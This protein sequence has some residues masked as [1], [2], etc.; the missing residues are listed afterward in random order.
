MTY[1]EFLDT[2]GFQESSNIYNKENSLGYIG[3]YQFG[4]SALIYIG[5]YVA[6]GTS[7]N[8]WIGNWTLA[9]GVSSKTAFLNNNNAQ[10]AAILAYMAKQWSYVNSV[11]QYEGQILNGVKITISGMLAGAHLV[12][13]VGEKQYLNSGGDVVPVDGNKTPITKYMQQF[14]G[15][16]TPFS[17][18][19]SIDETIKGGKGNDTLDGGNGFDTYIASNGDTLNDTDGKGKVLF[20]NIELR[21]GTKNSGETEWKDADGHTYS[22]LGSRLLITNSD[23]TSTLTIEN[24]SNDDL[25]IHLNDIDQ[26]TADLFNAAT[27]VTAPIRYDPLIFDLNGNGIESTG[28]SLTNPIYFDNDADGIKTATGWVSVNDAFL[29]LDKNSNGAIDDGRELF[30]D[31]MIKGNGE[32]ATDGFDALRDLDSNADGKIDSSDA[33]FA[34]LRLWQDLN[35]D[36]ISQSD[37]LFTL[38]SQNIAAINVGSTANNQILSNGNQLADVGSFIRTDGSSGTLG[39]VTGNIGDINLAQNTFLS[40]FVDHLDTSA[41][42]GLPDM[43]GAGQVRTLREAA[44]LS[45]TLAQLL[46][47]YRAA[48]DYS[49]RLALLDP[50]LTAWSDTSTLATTFNG[51]YSGHRLTVNIAGSVPGS[52]QYNAVANELTILEHFNGRTF[53]TVP[54]GTEAVTITLWTTTQ[55]LLQNSYDTLKQSV[56][57]SLAFQTNLKPYLDAISLGVS[58]T[59]ISLDFTGMNALLASN[60]QANPANA[61]FDLIELNRYAG[62]KLYSTGWDGI[63]QLQSWVE[64]ASGDTQL[65]TILTTMGVTL[66]PGNFSGGGADDM[67]F[68]QGGNDTLYGQAGNDILSGGTG[69]DSLNGGSGN[70]TLSGGTGNDTLVGEFGNDTLDGGASNDTLI[71]GTGNNT[72]LFGIG[73]GQD[74]INPIS[75]TTAGKLSTLQFKAGVAAADVVITQVYDNIFNGNR[76]LQIAIVG[77]TD[78]IIINGFFYNDDPTSAYNSVQQI[79]FADGAVWNIAT[80]QAMLFAGSSGNDAI[81]GT[82]ANDSLTGGLGNDSLNGAA[83]NDTING[84][85]GNDD[86]DGSA[87]IDTLL[88]GA[89]D[90][91]YRIGNSGDVIVEN[92]GE[93]FDVVRATASFV[94]S[95]NVENLILE[96]EGGNIGGTGNAD[97]NYIVGNKYANRLDGAKG[98]DIL[99]GGDGNDTYVIDNTMDQIIENATGGNDTV[100]SSITYTL[101]DILENLTLTRMENLNATGNNDNNYINGNSGNNQIDGGLGADTMA[102][103]AGDDRYIAVDAGDSINEYVGQGID[104]IERSCDTIYILENNVENLILMGTVIH[105]NGNDL[106]NVI[107][108][109]DADNNLSGL[110]GNDQLEGKVGNDALF[111]GTGVDTLIGGTGNDYYAVDDV[112]DIIIEAT[113]EG[114]DIVRSTVSF[115]LADNIERLALDG[116]ADLSATGNALDN[117]LWGNIG[118]NILNGGAENDYMVGNAGN[119]VYIFNHGDGQDTI[120]NTDLL[121]S[122]DTLRFGSG[123]ADTDVLAFQSGNDLLLKIKG[124][125]DQIYLSNYYGA[126]AVNGSEVSDHKID[127][128]EFANAVVWDQAALQTQVDRATYNHAPTINTYLPSLVTPIDKFFTYSVPVDTITDPDT[129]DSVS[130]SAK[131]PDGAALPTWL[132][133]DVATRTFSGTPDASNVGSLKVMLWGTDN[134]GSASGETMILDFAT[135]Q[136]LTGSAGADILIGAYGNDTLTGLADNDYLS[137]KTGND[138]YIFSRG[139]GQDTIDNTDLLTA[140]DTLRFGAGIADTDVLAFQSGNNLL[141][142]IKGSTDQIY[143]SNYYGADTVNG[144]EVSDHKIDRV[145]FTNGVAWDQTA[146][147]VQVD[148]STYNHAPVVNAYLPALQSYADNFFSYAVPLDTIIDSDVGD[149]ISYSVELPDGSALPS[150]LSFDAATRTVSGTPNSSQ[151]GSLSFILWGTDNYGYSAGEYVTLNTALP[152]HAPILSTA[153]ADQAASQGVAFSYTLPASAF[154]DPDAGDTL[155]YSATLADG[156]ALPSWLVFNAATHKFSGTPTTLG[157]TSVQVSATDSGG[158]KVS[159]IFDLVVSVQNLTVTGTSGADTLSGGMGHDTLN[160]L[161]GND[162][163]IGN[164]GNDTLNGGTGNDALKGGADDDT[165]IVDSATDSITE[166]LNEGFDSVQSSVSY[167]LANNLE[168]ILLTGTKTINATGNALNNVLTG[169]SASNTLTGGAG[170]DRLDGKAGSDK[171]IGGTGDDVY[172]VDITTDVITENAN[173]GIDTVESSI[174]LTLGANM[175][176]LTLAGAAALNGT[177]NALNNVLTGNNADNS[178]TGAVGN[179][180]LNGQGGVDTLSGGV[181]NDTYLLGRSYGIDSVVEND[182]T[183]GNSDIAQFIAGVTTNQLWFTHIAATN[184]LQINIIGTSDSFV[185]KDWYLSTANHIELFKTIDDTKMLTDSN[186]QNLVNAMSAFTPPALGQT[187]LPDNYLTILAP[188]IDSNWLVY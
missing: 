188:I 1:Q 73:D 132:N 144:S 37:E 139:D 179:D 153:L 19:H 24:F 116:T 148:R 182:S 77:A 98:A 142:K 124:S 114:D 78:N 29:V 27:A 66:E 50:I 159:D 49:T 59:G 60:Q 58:A 157:T 51:A 183:A 136:T 33:Q 13:H 180:I 99:E 104:T 118:N 151:V 143:F 105:G 48:G 80:I 156:S 137:G 6:D 26:A 93:G 113:G 17:V 45:T 129:W 108:G 22:R 75:N 54:T 86:L 158:L 134:Y 173:E 67:L 23:K 36:G 2:L 69:N 71:G 168:N 187:T 9:S 177:G 57:V 164:A 10:E 97:V 28:I 162:T 152:N 141:L 155:S 120:D 102:G 20:D 184:N 52:A 111:G 119:D 88:G 126:D 89:G 41:V 12:G 38:G 127:R 125:T 83:G 72:Y 65:Q 160:G 149:S 31:A 166:N 55:S 100:E 91:L 150:W 117:G 146:L 21:G 74:V 122:T 147:Q 39:E 96:N 35:Q 95:A 171:L 40:Q 112:N 62:T 90:D 85:D 167:V 68:G 175:E 25:G 128:V 101:S 172:V 176:N 15:Y 94:L 130:Y 115:T 11:R 3:K 140:T 56:Y 107:I 18:D 44:T 47:D 8:D 82:T 103:S 169:N 181:G 92:A 46:S 84:G 63:T 87:G 154:T 53:N 4:E 43:Q 16:D 106:D 135:P 14:A 123:I 170:N 131:L 178:L 32:L 121:T 5:Y 109:N 61:L 138:V 186:A 64:Q 161:A 163:L 133:F 174:S 70:D 110:G 76:A 7:K 30:G 81:R 42:T 185:I 34:N 145:E 79:V 165:Y